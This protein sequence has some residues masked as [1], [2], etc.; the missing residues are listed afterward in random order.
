FV[1]YVILYFI[2]FC[3]KISEL[4]CFL[5]NNF[6]ISDKANIKA[7]LERFYNED[8]IVAAKELLYDSLQDLKQQNVD[9]EIP[10]DIKRNRIGDKR[11][12]RSLE[13]IFELY[14]FADVK[15]A[16]EKLPKFVAYDIS[17]LPTL[18]MENVNSLALLNRLQMLESRMVHWEER[19]NTGQ[20]IPA[21]KPPV[22]QQTV[23]THHNSAGASASIA[24]NTVL[25]LDEFPSLG[26]TATA[27]S[28]VPNVSTTQGAWAQQSQRLNDIISSPQAIKNSDY[29]R[30]GISNDEF[31][32]VQ[33]KKKFKRLMGKAKIDPEKNDNSLS[34][35]VQI[36]PK[37]VVHIDNL[38]KN[39]TVDSIKTFLTQRNINVLSC[40][41][42]KSWLSNDVQ[43][44]VTSFRV[45]VERGCKEALMDVDLWPSGVII[46]EWRFK[47]KPSNGSND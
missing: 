19:F 34:C 6:A 1:F 2:L 17:R 12:K 42:A 27:M 47:P 3:I 29:N 16:I 15:T 13:D 11:M 30:G 22:S 7:L 4:L 32:V 8:E 26:S 44:Q 20:T 24:T 33:N 5:F 18:S 23:L 35:G 21:A 46:R 28:V 45:C 40:F 10:K 36:V 43:E 39:C 9:L 41:D 25:N 14:E 38:N 37:A 31:K